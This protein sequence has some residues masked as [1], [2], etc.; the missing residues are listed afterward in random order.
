LQKHF[1][2]V[3]DVLKCTMET[4]ECVGNISLSVFADDLPLTCIDPSTT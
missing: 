3:S 4:I 2:N 1:Q